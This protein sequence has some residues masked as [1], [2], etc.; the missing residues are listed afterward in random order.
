MA[1]PLIQPGEPQI[2][3]LGTAL[4]PHATFQGAEDEDIRNNFV[5][6]FVGVSNAG[7]YF[8]GEHKMYIPKTKSSGKYLDLKWVM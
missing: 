8:E 7:S 3:H 4:T 5:R 1:T 2:I 6:C